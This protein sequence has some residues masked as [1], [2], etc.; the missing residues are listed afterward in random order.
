MTP[1]VIAIATGELTNPLAIKAPPK[2]NPPNKVTRRGP[3]WSWRRPAKIIVIANEAVADVKGR[4]ASVLVQCQLPTSALAITPQAYNTPRTRL[5]PR[6]ASVTAQAL[7][8]VTSIELSVVV[9]FPTVMEALGYKLNNFAT[10]RL[11]YGGFYT[12]VTV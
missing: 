1:K 10:I 4:E 9:E 11:F 12:I 5:I 6:A 7:A 3:I 8:G 2:T